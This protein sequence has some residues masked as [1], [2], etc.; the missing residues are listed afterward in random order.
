[1]FIHHAYPN[2]TLVRQNLHIMSDFYVLH[3]KCEHC[4]PVT[5]SYRMSSEDTIEIMR[6]LRPTLARHTAC[7]MPSN[8]AINDPKA[9]RKI[10]LE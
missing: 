3:L 8:V 6:E 7:H 1:M 9:I 2:L 4:G 5:A 10:T